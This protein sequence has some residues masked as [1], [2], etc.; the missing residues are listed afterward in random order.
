MPLVQAVFVIA[1]LECSV[2][3]DMPDRQSAAARPPSDRLPAVAGRRCCAGAQ[4]KGVVL[5]TPSAESGR[6]RDD[7]RQRLDLSVAIVRALAHC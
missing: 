6:V 2:A 7:G 4:V 1:H 5:S 3:Q